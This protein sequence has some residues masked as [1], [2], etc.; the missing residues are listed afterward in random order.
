[1]AVEG[2]ILVKCI[3]LVGYIK[4]LEQYNMPTSCLAIT[5]EENDIITKIILMSL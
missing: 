5:E 4:D 2:Y 3:F 1:M